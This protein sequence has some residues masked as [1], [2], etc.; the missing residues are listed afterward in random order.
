MISPSNLVALGHMS[1]CSAFDVREQ[2]ERLVHEV[3]VVVV[4]AVHRPGALAGLPDLVLL[5]RH[6]AQLGEDLLA[7]AALLGQRAVDAEPLGVGIEVEEVTHR[8]AAP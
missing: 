7:G 6:L 5:G 3:V 8:V 1:R 2:P 4:A